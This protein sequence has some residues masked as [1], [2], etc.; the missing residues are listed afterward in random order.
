[1]I[2]QII[3]IVMAVAIVLLLCGYVRHEYMMRIM[4]DDIDCALSRAVNVE[5][6]LEGHIWGAHENYS[7]GDDDKKD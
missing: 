5:D 7:V 4:A 2:T 1:M 3:I 6:A